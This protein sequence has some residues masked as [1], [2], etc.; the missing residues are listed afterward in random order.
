MVVVMR[1][2]DTV[3][4]GRYIAF[5]GMTSPRGVK[6]VYRRVRSPD[7]V[8]CEYPCNNATAVSL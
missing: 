7:G 8:F 3:A 2:I 6:E 1:R 5:R 4:M